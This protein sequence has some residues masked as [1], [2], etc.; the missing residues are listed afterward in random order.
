MSQTS[1]ETEQWSCGTCGDRDVPEKFRVFGS[2]YKCAAQRSIDKRNRKIEQLRGHAQKPIGGFVTVPRK[3]TKQMLEAGAAGSGEDSEGCALG[4]WE[5]MIDA[6]LADTSTDRLCPDCGRSID[7]PTHAAY[8]ADS[9][10]PSTV[11]GAIPERDILPDEPTLEQPN[12]PL[13]NVEDINVLLEKI[14]EKFEGWE[15]LDLWRSDAA[16]TVRGFKRKA[17]E[18]KRS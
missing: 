2:C 1:P 3:P 9:T 8:C 6:A 17:Q 12:F 16:A 14:A 10:Q 5:A 7:G 13:G 4:A 15:T 18:E 11:R